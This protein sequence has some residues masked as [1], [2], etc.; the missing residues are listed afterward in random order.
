MPDRRLWLRV[1]GGGHA[2]LLPAGDIREVVPAGEVS[3]LP[4]RPAGI[5]GV[6]I[7]Q[8]EFLPVL[9]W[10]DLPGCG[11]GRGPTAAL[12]ILRPRLGLPLEGVDGTGPIEEEAIRAVAEADPAS[13][14]CAGT[15]LIEGIEFRV[16]DA[17]RLVLLL[18]RLRGER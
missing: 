9:A 1:R 4:G 16:L 18:R 13:A 10:K 3:P 5:Q 6:V 15:I 14:W 12:A 8:G 17:D 2:L 7:H 11:Q